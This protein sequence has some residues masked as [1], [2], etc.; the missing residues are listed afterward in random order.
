VYAFFP[1]WG[2]FMPFAMLTH[3][4]IPY[5]T[6]FTPALARERLCAG[7]DAEVVTVVGQPENRVPEWIAAVGWPRPE[8]TRYDQRDGAPV[9]HVV[10]WRAANR[11][12]DSCP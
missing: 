10:R 4:S 11:A 6:V 1:D 2:V 8:V 7:Q 12:P 3:G 9:L 5:T